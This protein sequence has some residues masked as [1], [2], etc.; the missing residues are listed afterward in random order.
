MRGNGDSIAPIN[1]LPQGSYLHVNTYAHMVLSLLLPAREVTLDNGH[2]SL[3]ATQQIT[4]I[5]M[6]QRMQNPIS[7]LSPIIYES[8]SLPS[9]T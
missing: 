8:A 2:D 7:G 4:W 1:Q 6:L 5:A 3:N 9:A